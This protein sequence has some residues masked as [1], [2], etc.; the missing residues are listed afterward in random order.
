MILG[1]IQPTEGGVFLFDDPVKGSPIHIRCKIGVVS[2]KQH[3]YQKMTLREYLDLF[4][5]LY[6]IQKRK[7][8]IE[9]VA[10]WVDLF[11]MLD[12]QLGAFSRGMQQKVGFARALL[13]EPDLLILDEP[14][15][16]LDPMGIRQVRQ[17]IEKQS[18]EGKTVFI[19]SHMLSEIEKL[20]HRV[21]IM[22][23]GRLLAEDRMDSIIRRVTGE[24]E[25]HI[26]FPEQSSQAADALKGLDFVR[27]ISVNGRFLKVKI[28][29]DRDY[30][31]RVVQSFI[32]RGLFPIGI[33]MRSISLEDA[34]VTI[35]NQNISLLAKA[36]A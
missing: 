13:H 16:G 8:R 17:L 30:R 24:V 14:I 31:Q 10:E 23:K 28:K 27:V 6:R 33:Q 21:G 9:E 19:S 34:F 22:N 26:E 3:L 5:E 32:S 11:D 18:R 29:T 7:A 12:T 35:T 25:L 1:I 20:C 15:S 2:E 36:D 4:G